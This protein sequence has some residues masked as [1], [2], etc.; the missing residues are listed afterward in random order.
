MDPSATKK[1]ALRPISSH[2]G[3]QQSWPPVQRLEDLYEQHQSREGHH[4]F[5][6]MGQE[7]SDGD[8]GYLIFHTIANTI[9]LIY[10]D[11][12]GKVPVH[13]SH[14]YLHFNPMRSPWSLLVDLSQ[15]FQSQQIY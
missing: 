8:L 6:M 3:D 12:Q 2:L 14:N 13:Y 1:W 7:E 5:W 15:S 10:C 9:H 4:S 11:L